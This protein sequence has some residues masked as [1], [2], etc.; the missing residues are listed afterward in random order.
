M[1]DDTQILKLITQYVWAPL[2][3]VIA[4][5]YGLVFGIKRDLTNHRI[6]TAQNMV[7][8]KELA[9]MFNALRASQDKSH[10]EL[11]SAHKDVTEELR[12]LRNVFVE[13]LADNRKK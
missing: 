9:E 7:T 1:M 2:L 11:K 10:D 4:Y 13:Y 5:L 12:Q 6:D 3:A 8:R